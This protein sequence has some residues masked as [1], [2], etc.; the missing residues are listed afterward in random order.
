VVAAGLEAD[1]EFAA[2]LDATDVVGEVH[3]GEAP[4]VR[5]AR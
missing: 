3:A 4:V 2:R 5:A 1:I